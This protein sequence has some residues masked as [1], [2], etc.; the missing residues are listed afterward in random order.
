MKSAYGRINPPKVD[1]IAFAMISD[2]V[3]FCGR[4]HITR[5]WSSDFI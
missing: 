1:E 5:G 4:F 3:G 2:F